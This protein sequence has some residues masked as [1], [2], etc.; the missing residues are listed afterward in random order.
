[1][2][3]ATFL[4]LLPFFW[5][6]HFLVHVSFP[7]TNLKGPVSTLKFQSC[8]AFHSPNPNWKVKTMN[9]SPKHQGKLIS[10][11]DDTT[12][13]QCYCGVGVVVRQS[14]TSSNPN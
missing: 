5:L 4:S 6:T 12:P 9:N 7:S 13:G 2:C 8:R 11:V 10:H 14:R 1:V 3:F